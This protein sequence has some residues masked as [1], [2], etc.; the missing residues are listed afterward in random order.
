MI[1]Y[2]VF[3]F[4]AGY[5]SGLFKESKDIAVSTLLTHLPLLRPGNAEAK[6]EYLKIIPKILSHSIENGCHIEESRQLL[7]YSLIHPAILSEERSQFTYWLGHL[8]ERFTYNIYQQQT[9]LSQQQQQAGSQG[10]ELPSYLQYT[11]NNGGGST[12]A[13]PSSSQHGH[14][15][16]GIR[17][18]G[19]QHAGSHDRD[20]GILVNGLESSGAGSLALNGLGGALTASNNSVGAS[21]GN[22]GPNGHIPLHATSSGPANYNSLVPSAQGKNILSHL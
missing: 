1:T 19:W 16:P 4:L 10:N 12:G 13:P 22:G 18:N 15:V 20:S 6:A 14:I 17:L 7:S 5:V 2:Y 21:G 9:R 11:D 8:E 3:S